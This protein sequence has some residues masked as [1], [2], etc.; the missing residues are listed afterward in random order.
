MLESLVNTQPRAA[1]LCS[2][3]CF[4]KGFLI[5]TDKHAALFAELLQWP[6]QTYDLEFM[7]RIEGMQECKCSGIWCTQIHNRIEH[8]LT[9]LRDTAR[10][11]VR[12]LPAVVKATSLPTYMQKRPTPNTIKLTTFHSLLLNIPDGMTKIICTMRLETLNIQDLDFSGH[13]IFWRVSWGG[14]AAT[15]GEHRQR[16]GHAVKSCCSLALHWCFAQ[17][18]LLLWISLPFCL[19]HMSHSIRQSTK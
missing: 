1:R 11:K 17:G 5:S 18:S 8:S 15:E 14:G 19:P 10:H 16:E 13:L 3:L 4:P 6:R 9:N 2:P 7:I 12:H